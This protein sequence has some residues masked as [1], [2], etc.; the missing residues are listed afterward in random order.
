MAWIQVGDAVVNTDHIAR[1][2][3][4]EGGETTIILSSGQILKAPVK[5]AVPLLDWLKRQTRQS[6]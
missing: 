6:S 2:A 3:P 5:D 4:G 1:I